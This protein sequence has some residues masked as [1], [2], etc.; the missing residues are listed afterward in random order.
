MSEYFARVCVPYILYFVMILTY[1]LTQT[2]LLTFF[3][4]LEQHT[5]VLHVNTIY[6]VDNKG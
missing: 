6:S 3:S 2:I 5:D 4:K 1:I